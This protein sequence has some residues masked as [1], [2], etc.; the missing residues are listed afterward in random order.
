MPPGSAWIDE[1]SRLKAQL[2]SDRRWR[3]MRVL[4][5]QVV[6][7]RLRWLHRQVE[8]TVGFLALRE[9]A[10]NALLVLGGEERR[11]V[12]ESERRLIASRQLPTASID[13]LTDSELEGMLYGNC[14]VDEATLERRKA[15]ALESMTAGP[16]PDWFTEHPDAASI[17][18]VINADRLEGWAASPGRVTGPVRIVRSLADGARLKPGEVMVA[19][20]TD[21]SWTPLFLVAS[22]IVLE[23]GGPLS[24]AAIIA[25]EFGLPAVLNVRQATRALS[26]GEIVLVDGSLGIVDRIDPGGAW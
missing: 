14:G 20:A 16:L 15:A 2:S 6:D 19:H 21:P 22:G 3:R 18:D 24:H 11:I 12:L 1:F 17:P 7:M 10:K 23:M 9:R 25:R 13:Y 5:G 8:E 4:T 26:E